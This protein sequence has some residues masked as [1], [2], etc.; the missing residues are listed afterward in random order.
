MIQPK[1]TVSGYRGVWG[2][3]LNEEIVRRYTRAFAHFLK[4]DQ[5]SKNPILLIGRDGRESGLT[6]RKA[7][8]EELTAQGIDFIDGDI[9]PTPTVIFSVREHKYAGGIIITASHNP[10]E[11]NGLKFVNEKALFLN[12]AESEKINKYCKEARGDISLGSALGGLFFSARKFLAK[13]FLCPLPSL[14]PRLQK[15]IPPRSLNSPDFLK[16]HADRIVQSVDAEAIRAKKFK[17]AVDMIN[18]SACALDPY[19]FEQLGVELVPLN[20]IPNGKFAHMPEPKTENLGEISNFVKEQGANLGFAQ[21]P[22]ADRLVVINEK[23]EVGYEEHTMAL[24][25]EN[26]LSKNPGQPVVINLSTSRMSRDIAEKYGSPCF[27]TKVGEPNVVAGIIEHKAIIGGEGNGGVIYPAVNFTRDSFVGIA[28]I[29]E[30]L[31]KSGKTA[32]QLTEALPKYFIKKEKWPLREEVRNI[33][34][35]MKAYFSTASSIEIDGICLEFPDGAWLH[36]HPSNT[37][38]IF[39]L[40]GEATAKESIEAL[41]A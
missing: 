41:F 27:M 10:I 21:D 32:S 7:V 6:I 18:A 17:V 9:L 33:C 25:V 13:N 38:Q 11:Y 5:K 29:L 40:Y 23:G 14:L 8:K 34:A 19:L 37:E 4:E 36:L 12:E 22:D 3:T 2:E 30:L 24:A 16:E 35:R 15:T 31:A 1:F 26:V 39:R 28:L 20:N